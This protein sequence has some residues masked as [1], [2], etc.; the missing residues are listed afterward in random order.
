MNEAGGVQVRF[1]AGDAKECLL[2][3]ATGFGSAMESLR[4]RDFAL[5]IELVSDV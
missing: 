5:K 2:V 3:S 1:R 4:E